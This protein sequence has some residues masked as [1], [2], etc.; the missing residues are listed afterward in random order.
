MEE[1]EFS[2]IS[3][4][5]FDPET[6]EVLAAG[7]SVGFYNKTFDRLTTKSAKPVSIE[8]ASQTNYLPLASDPVIAKL[9]TEMKELSLSWV[10]P[11]LLLLMATPRS[12]NPWDLVTKRISPTAV[13]V[14]QREDAQ[15][16]SSFS[17]EHIFVSETAN[18]PP[19]M[20]VRLS[21]PLKIWPLKLLV[22][23][24]SCQASFAHLTT[25]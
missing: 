3:K 20:I 12:V 24:M 16:S 9:A 11:L 1:V 19:L 2:R 6:P 21:I 15:L 22:S 17:L 8:E 23:I 25:N 7:G 14:D 10:M 4:L 5:Q 18:E 13:I